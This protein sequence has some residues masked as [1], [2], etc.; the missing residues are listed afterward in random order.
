MPLQ[1]A[2]WCYRH[3]ALPGPIHGVLLLGTDGTTSIHLLN[4][5]AV[6]WILYSVHTCHTGRQE[7]VAA[8]C[9]H[10]ES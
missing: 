2:G 3:S 9:C 4:R 6:D 1:A 5:E 10:L 7:K 8:C